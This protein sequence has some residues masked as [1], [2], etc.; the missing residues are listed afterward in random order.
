MP[1]TINRILIVP[2]KSKHHALVLQSWFTLFGVARK[3][4]KENGSCNSLEPTAITWVRRVFMGTFF[5]IVYCSSELV[6]VDE[7][8]IYTHIWLTGRSH[9]PGPCKRPVSYMWMYILR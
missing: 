2:D 3:G 8:R 4:P 1:D 6:N 9:G 5:E 7:R